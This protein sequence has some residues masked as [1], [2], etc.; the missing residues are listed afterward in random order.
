MIGLAVNRTAWVLQERQNT[1]LPQTQS[2][3]DSHQDSRLGKLMVLHP[4][5]N[6]QYTPCS[7]EKYIYN[8]NV[9]D[10]E[11]NILAAPPKKDTKVEGGR[12]GTPGG[13][14]QFLFLQHCGVDRSVGGL[15]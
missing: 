6:D 9:E 8:F 11:V 4:R 14:A 2:I 7:K 13:F 5:Q 12:E 3:S 15:I 1:S 10:A